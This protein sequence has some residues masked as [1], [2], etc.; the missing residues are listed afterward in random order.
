MVWVCGII[1]VTMIMVMMM[2]VVVVLE[3]LSWWHSR[4]IFCGGCSTVSHRVS[5]ELYKN[6]FALSLTTNNKQ[7][8]R[9]TNN[10]SSNGNNNPSFSSVLQATKVIVAETFPQLNLQQ[11]TYDPNSS[12]IYAIAARSVCAY[13][14]SVSGMWSFPFCC[15][16]YFPSPEQ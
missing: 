16:P 15:V 14:R 8:Q 7:D 10:N 11:H 9:I 6:L 12:I 2:V 4:S 3:A 13:V 1:F 5:G